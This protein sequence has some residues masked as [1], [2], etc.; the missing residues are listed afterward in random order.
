MIR[1]RP[2]P[3][4]LVATAAETR[5]DGAISAQTTLRPTMPPASRRHEIDLLALL[6]AL[7]GIV[8]VLAVTLG[9]S[10]LV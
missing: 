4:E 9:T 6:V 10:P 8:L 2:L 5:P 1:D 7:F 3:A